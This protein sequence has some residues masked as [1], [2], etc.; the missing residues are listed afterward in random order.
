MKNGVTIWRVADVIESAAAN[1]TQLPSGR[2]VPA[3]PLGWTS[4]SMRWK[5]AWLVFTG[6][7]DA[8]M[9]EGQ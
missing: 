2:W 8:L 7:A 9:W 3:R 6:K 1:S 5:A 4:L